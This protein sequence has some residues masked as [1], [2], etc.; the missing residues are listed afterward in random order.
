MGAGPSQPA[1]ISAAARGDVQ[2]VKA[3]LPRPAEVNG[4]DQVSGMTKL[5]FC[6][7]AHVSM[8]CRHSAVISCRVAG[9]HFMRQPTKIMR[10][11]VRSSSS[12]VQR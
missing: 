4:S 7:S 2:A 9:E 8:Q 3:L 11:S 6:S 10:M 12:R 1:L 5:L